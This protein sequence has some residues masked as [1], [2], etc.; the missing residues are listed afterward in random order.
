MT[1][2]SEI[3]S[4]VVTLL[5]TGALNVVPIELRNHVP[6]EASSFVKMVVEGAAREGAALSC[7]RIAPSFAA[8]LNDFDAPGTGYQGV[9]IE[10]VPSLGRTIQFVLS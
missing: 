2:L 8:D 7:V 9:P 6:E 1:T 10:L 3:S 4:A 5:K